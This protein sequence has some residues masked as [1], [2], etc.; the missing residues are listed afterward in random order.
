MRNSVSAIVDKSLMALAVI[1]GF[2]VISCAAQSAK[3]PDA[4]EP[5][6]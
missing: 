1:L 5:G 2:W 4:M 3:L 6:T